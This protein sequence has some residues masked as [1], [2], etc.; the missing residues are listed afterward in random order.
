MNKTIDNRETQKQVDSMILKILNNSYLWI[1]D[2][3]EHFSSFEKEFKKLKYLGVDTKSM[4]DL[5]YRDKSRIYRYGLKAR[6]SAWVMK[7]NDLK[8]LIIDADSSYKNERDVA[9]AFNKIT[10]NLIDYLVKYKKREVGID[11]LLNFISKGKKSE[12][13]VK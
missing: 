4:E 7:G 6:Y 12:K 10:L 11:D 13:V 5:I 1:E 9:R 8:Y 2:M 3:T